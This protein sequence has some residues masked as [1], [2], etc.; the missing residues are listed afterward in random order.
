MQIDGLCTVS[1]LAK[2]F[3]LYWPR[4]VWPVLL[5]IPFHGMD[6]I[7]GDR[8]ANFTS[9]TIQPCLG[10]E[11]VRPTIGE[12]THGY[13]IVIGINHLEV[14]LHH[15]GANALSNPVDHRLRNGI[16]IGLHLRAKRSSVQITARN[17]IPILEP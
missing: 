11:L 10:D 3:E 8:S 2:N 7:G 9:R 15:I 16:V 1:I 6:S 14:K 17:K 12:D 4:T 5:Y 13:I